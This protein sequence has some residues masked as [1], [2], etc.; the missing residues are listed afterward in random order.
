MGNKTYSPIADIHH[1]HGVRVRDLVE[2]EDGNIF[3]ICAGFTPQVWVRIW[4]LEGGRG[5]TLMDIPPPPQEEYGFLCG[6]LIKGGGVLLGGCYGNLF[7]FNYKDY[8]FHNIFPQ[9]LHQR[10]ICEIKLMG[11]DQYLTCSQDE[12]IILVDI[13][14]KLF[15]TLQGHTSDVVSILPIFK[16]E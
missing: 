7:I 10:G 2:L 12:T 11:G 4:V 13:Y 9:P 1:G 5:R 3:S 15:K 16:G 8:V 14:H 6:L